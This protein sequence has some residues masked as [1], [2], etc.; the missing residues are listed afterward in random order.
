M[1]KI[2]FVTV[3]AALLIGIAQ[4]Y[5]E[6]TTNEVTPFSTTEWVECANGGAGEMVTLSGS[7]HYLVAVTY[8]GNG[9]YHIKMQAN[10]AGVSGTG[11][12]TGDKYRMTGVYQTER[13]GT[14]GMQNTITQTFMVVG[15][16]KGNNFV[17]HEVDH[18]TVLPDGTVIIDHETISTEC[19]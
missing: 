9:G 19:K 2:L 14:V 12:I 17:L 3:M 8:D 1:K 18:F 4:A 7:V 16:G 6:V 11:D 10:P 15:Q 13:N 5:G